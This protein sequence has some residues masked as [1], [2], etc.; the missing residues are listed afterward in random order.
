MRRIIALFAVSA[1]LAGA[2]GVASPAPAEAAPALKPCGTIDS[3]RKLGRDCAGPLVVSVNNIRVDLGGRK[4]VCPSNTTDGIILEG[5]SGVRIIKGHVHGCSIGVRIDGGSGNTLESLHVDGNAWQGILVRGSSNNVIRLTQV[6]AN[7]TTGRLGARGVMVRRSDDGTTSSDNNLLD[8]VTARQ[9]TAYGIEI[10]GSA[11]N[12]I[13]GSV[14]DANATGGIA[15]DGGATGTIVDASS[16][17]GN[18]GFG[19]FVSG[20]GTSIVSNA[21]SSNSGPAGWGVQLTGTAIDTELVGNVINGNLV[22]VRVGGPDNAIADNTLA[23]N[24]RDGIAVGLSIG[25]ASPTGNEVSGNA[26]SGSGRYDLADFVAGAC[27]ANAW[28]GNSGVR[29][30]DG[31][32]TAA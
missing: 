8:R 13:T 26:A 10:N 24:T 31:C 6:L 27:T 1:I 9:N 32:E 30:F 17:S 4:V 29:L 20:T 18:G 16:G 5:R 14:A 21:F 28:H 12:R 19:I 2:W 22:G 25:A 23:G 15:I 7:G 11:G 3:D